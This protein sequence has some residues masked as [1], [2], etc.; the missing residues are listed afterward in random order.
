[1]RRHRHI[2]T[3]VC[4]VTS[5]RKTWAGRGLHLS[6]TNHSQYSRAFRWGLGEGKKLRTEA[7]PQ[8][9]L[10]RMSVSIS[11]KDFWDVR[12]LLASRDLK[13]HSHHVLTF[14]DNLKFT[15]VF[16]S[17]ENYLF[18][19]PFLFP[20]SWQYSSFNLSPRITMYTT[21]CLLWSFM[22]A[23]GRQDFFFIIFKIQVLIV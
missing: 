14:T 19:L 6:V 1:M 2:C 16:I 8:G 23:F 17:T 9:W 12:F 5:V 20:V 10:L 15:L 4:W 13:T 3:K 7:S 18:L 22:W 11:Y 21:A